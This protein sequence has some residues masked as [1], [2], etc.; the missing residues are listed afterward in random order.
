MVRSVFVF[1]CVFGLI[2]FNNGFAID[3]DSTDGGST[4]VIPRGYTRQQYLKSITDF[5]TPERMA[6]AIPL[7]PVINK[8]SQV[9]PS[10]KVDNNQPERILSISTEEPGTRSAIPKAAGRIFFT[11]AG[12]TYVCSGSVVT[13]NN[14]DLVV[15]AGHC[16]YNTTTKQYV[17][18]LVF[19]P[20]YESGN[21]PVGTFVARFMKATDKWE[22]GV[23]YNNDVAI[24]LM[25]TN[26][27]GEHVQDLCGSF[28][29]VINAPAQAQTHAFGY[30]MNINNGETMSNCID[31]SKTPSLILMGSFKGLQITCGMGGGA[32]GGPWLRSYNSNNHFGQQVSLTSFSYTFAPG[33]IHGP[34][35]SADN[36]GILFNNYQN[37]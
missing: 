12:Q 9:S 34:H 18:N 11:M 7:H 28:G 22:K 17:N 25:N 37:K 10:F 13:S 23:D 20:H 1:L 5:W 16:V 15:T 14:R 8:I 29:L 4:L 2:H 35:F 27:N 24:V 32:S 19:A 3:I 33:K 21:R 31:N 26:E 36:I 6:S 30:P